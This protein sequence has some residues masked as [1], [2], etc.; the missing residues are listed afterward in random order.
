ML[1]LSTAAV[2]ALL[3]NPLVQLGGG[4]ALRGVG[5]GLDD[6]HGYVQLDL[7]HRQTAELIWRAQ[8]LAY[9]SKILAP[10]RKARPCPRFHRR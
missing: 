2:V 3:N 9:A 4:L 8:A 1:T 5:Y 10:Q 7:Y 6:L